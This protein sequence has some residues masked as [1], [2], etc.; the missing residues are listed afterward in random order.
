MPD[1]DGTQDVSPFDSAGGRAL[2]YAFVLTQSA[3]LCSRRSGTGRNNVAR[4]LLRRSTVI[5]TPR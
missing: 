2:P 1:C 5:R 3:N 4:L